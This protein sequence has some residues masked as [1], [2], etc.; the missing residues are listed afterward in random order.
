MS[1]NLEAASSDRLKQLL[2]KVSNNKIVGVLIGATATI[3]IQSSSAT[4]VMA[5]GF[6]N[7]K[8]I[9]LMQAAAIIFGAEIGTTLTGQLV[10]LGMLGSSEISFNV[11]FSALAGLG[12]FVTMFSKHDNVKL[13][14]NVMTGLGL[15]FAGLGSMSSAMSGF[16]QYPQ[17][18]DLIATFKSSFLLIIIGAVLTAIIQSSSA[19]T[20]ISITMVAAGLV[21]ISQGIYLT[22]GANVGTC[23]TGVLAGAKAESV[24][25]KRTS[26]L[27]LIFNI[28][29]VVLVY[30]SDIILSLFSGGKINYG[31]LLANMFPNVPHTQLAMFHTIFNIA[32]VLIV[33]PFTEKL[34]G[35]TEKLIADEPT[36]NSGEHFYYVNEN[37]ISTP[38]VAVDQIKQEIVNMSNI[39][40]QNFNIAVDMIKTLNFD[41][42]EDFTKNEKE[43]NFLNENLVDLV[44][45]VAQSGKVN[46]KDL[47][48]LSSTYR[49]ISDLERIGDYAENIVR[50][51]HNL[52]SSESPFSPRLLAEMEAM[53]TLINN[54]Y[55]L[56][57]ASYK[58]GKKKLSKDIK[59]LKDNIDSLSNHMTDIYITRL[60]QNELSGTSGTD[61]LKYYND[62]QRIGSHLINLIDTDYILSH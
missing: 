27:Q 19:M 43:L 44:L 38:S 3:V 34:V 46:R 4:T 42:E 37:I 7:A 24:N 30:L 11:L 49:A 59:G 56:V 32:S 40:I 20:S 23:L 62:T 17:L 12:V 21:N 45:K 8:I 53:R 48:Y 10:A 25:A 31:I 41:R 51:A 1:S 18:K 14:G 47:S 6:V 35:L 60:N 9:S 57:L 39:A 52:A 50:Y 58:D 16:S 26:L 33:L 28:G 36:D 55:L 5:I 61:Y 22:L 29:G 13:I 15:L 2:A 54:L